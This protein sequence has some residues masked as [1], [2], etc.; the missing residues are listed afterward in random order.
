MT[1]R[2][3]L[4][5]SILMAGALAG[6]AGDSG[7]SEG[8]GSSAPLQQ[9]GSSTVYPIAE[10]WAEELAAEGIQVT[11]AGGGSGAGASK[12]CAKE[13]DLADMSRKMKQSEIDACKANGV[14]PVE[15]TVAYDG[16]SIVV[17]KDNA[18]V[19]HLTV[20]ELRKIWMTGSTVRTW[21][22]VREGW[23]AETILLYGADSDSGT[24]EYFNEEVLG[25]TC[26]ADGKQLCGPRNDYSATA[27][28]TSIVR[29]V[30]ASEHALGYFGYS[31]LFENQDTLRAVPIV[32][33]GATDPVTPTFETIRDGSY[34]PFSRPLFVYTDGVP[35]AGSAAHTY[36]EYAFG[37]GQGL[38]RE[39]GF[40]ELDDATVQT[41]RQQLGA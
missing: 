24:Y 22:D 19:D 7:S 33:K 16:L 32:A 34:K 15:W 12:L 8:G 2:T 39:L 37:D 13:I 17:S 4:I 1:T 18:F 31:Y 10:A 27:E 20:E 21:A 14:D 9:A 11:V 26:G 38:M 35:A 5:L 29:G 28:D 3:I 25:K 41:M 36:L 40:V 30:G 6:C 23:P